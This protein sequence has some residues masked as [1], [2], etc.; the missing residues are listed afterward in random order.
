VH[1]APAPPRRIQCL[2]QRSDDR[3]RTLRLESPLAGEQTREVC[4]LHV[5]HSDEEQ[6]LC[7]TGL[8]NGDDAR[9]VERGGEFRLAQEPL[10]ETLA[11]A[12]LRTQEFERDPPV[13]PLVA[14]AIDD[15]HPAASERRLDPI[16][17]KLSAD[18]GID[19][20]HTPSPRSSKD[21]AEGH[22]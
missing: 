6:P 16:A 13:Q 21:S 3:K 19:L 7:L 4:A 2:S 1:E 17:S 20:Y 14:G 5:A 15:R 18:P 10:A 11:R 22:A 9:M 8:V 12:E